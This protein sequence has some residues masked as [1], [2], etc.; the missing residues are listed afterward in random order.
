MTMGLRYTPEKPCDVIGAYRGRFFAIESKQ[1]KKFEAFGM[2][3]MRPAQI[4]H[5][6]EI[7]KTGS[8]AFV[9]L[10]I[11]V[12]AIK[13][14]QKRENRLIIF[15]WQMFRGLGETTMKKQAVMDMP[16]LAYQSVDKKT[17]YDLK[18]FLAAL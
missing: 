13:G 3:H 17:I 6:D 16:Y 10:N 1:L 2:R 11:R 8:K 7:V 15:H 18:H 12:P 5:L 4:R 14:K 9:F